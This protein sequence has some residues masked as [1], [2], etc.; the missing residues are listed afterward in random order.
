MAEPTTTQKP[1]AK[2]GLLKSLSPKQKRYAAVIGAGA[3]L[4]LLY[5]LNRSRSS[6]VGQ[7][8][9]DSTTAVESSVPP[10]GAAAGGGEEGSAF[11]GAQGSA[12]TERL[13][14]VSAG[15]SEVGTGLGVLGEGQTVMGESESDFHTSQEQANQRVAAALG[16]QNRQ[17]TAL[18]KRLQTQ[19]PAAPRR[20]PVGHP[21]GKKAPA[22]KKAPAR[23]PAKKA[24]A[25]KHKR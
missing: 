1:G 5:L 13:G 15:L 25:K 20:S 6:E 18:R 3:L 10:S 14:E 2:G 11:A 12:I 9:S 21:A 17:L 16:K 22:K 4:A 8:P 24:P 7:S 19:R 23:H